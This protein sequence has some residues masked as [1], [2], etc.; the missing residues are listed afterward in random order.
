MRLWLRATLLAIFGAG[1]RRKRCFDLATR[2]KYLVLNS[3]SACTENILAKPA[4][5]YL[6]LSSTLDLTD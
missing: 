5:F 6:F 3:L 1:T 2:L 4:T